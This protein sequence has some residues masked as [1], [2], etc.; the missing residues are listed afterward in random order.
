[1][2]NLLIGISLII[3]GFLIKY[4]QWSFLIAGYNTAS[5]EEKE[6]YDKTALC[7]GLGKIL[8]LLGGILFIA[9]LGDFLEISW[10]LNF[11][12]ILFSVVILFFV[13]YANTGNRYKK[14]FL[15][16]FILCLFL[17]LS[18]GTSLALWDW[19][20][21]ES[22]NFVIFYPGGYE[23]QAKESLYYLEEYRPEI[24]E[25]TGNEMK[26][27]KIHISL[28]DIGLYVNG[29]ADFLNN[30]MGIFVTNPDS[31]SRLSNYE[32]WL[33]LVNIHELTYMAQ[34]TN[35]SD[36]SLFNT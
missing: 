24:I 5:K 15:I 4:R 23:T 36:L 33:I 31:Y 34:L 1:M 20:T 19:E 27:R 25:L 21:L 22:D 12:W 32:N 6:Q 16:F 17:I 29:Y 35:S 13:I 3:L 14:Y 8:F 9:F 11:S 7:N 2:I 10:L 26:G 18:N 28:E 30:K